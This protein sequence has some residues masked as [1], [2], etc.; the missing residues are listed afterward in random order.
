M[1][2]RAVVLVTL[3]SLALAAGACGGKIAPEGQEGGQ[4]RG[5]SGTGAGSASGSGAVGEPPP[6]SF[7][8]PA[9]TASP[10]P[11]SPDRP[12]A[13][14][15]ASPPDEGSDCGWQYG[16]PCDYSVS[17]SSSSCAVQCICVGSDRS[18]NRWTCFDIG[19]DEG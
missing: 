14:C 11:G 10:P 8:T 1:R 3:L 5:G 16:I 2:S 19:C 7:T 17:R 18:T 13:Q 12:G 9:P 6:G 15:P 4:G